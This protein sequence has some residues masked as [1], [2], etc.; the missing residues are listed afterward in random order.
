ML[1]Q[2]QPSAI[3]ITPFLVSLLAARR[4]IVISARY[5]RFTII[6]GGSIVELLFILTQKRLVQTD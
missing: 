2:K 3:T 4:L 6:T 5:F 1:S